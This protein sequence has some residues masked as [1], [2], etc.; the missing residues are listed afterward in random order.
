MNKVITIVVDEL[1]AKQI[2]D[3]YYEFAEFISMETEAEYDMT[4]DGWATWDGEKAGLDD[5]D[6]EDC[7]CEDDC[8]CDDDDNDDAHRWVDRRKVEI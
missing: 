3:E 2:F 4:S 1:M 7:D 8:T 6:A 5:D